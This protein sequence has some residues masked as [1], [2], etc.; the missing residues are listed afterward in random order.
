MSATKPVT[1]EE[2]DAFMRNYLTSPTDVTARLVFADW[3]EETCEPHNLA[4]AYYIRLRAEA[5]RHPLDSPERRELDRQADSYAPKV[6]ANL[7]I[8]ASLF[9]GYPKSLLQ[10][11]PA[12]N[13]TVRL[14][15]VEIP[16]AVLELVPESVARDN[17]VLSLDLQGSTLLV[18]AADPHNYDTAQKLQFIL[19]RDIVM[20]GAEE[21]DLGRAIDRLYE[22]TETETVECVFYEFPENYLTLPADNPVELTSDADAPVVRLANLIVQE[23]TSLRADRILITPEPDGVAVR[24]RSDD[25]WIDRDRLP[26]RLLG[27][28]S[29]RFAI[30]A[31]IPVEWTFRNPPSLTPWTAVFPLQVGGTLFHLRVTLQ[32]SPDGS[33]TQIDFIR[34]PQS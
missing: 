32:P 33:T 30:M 16:L 15:E 24:L 21:E 9:V 27:S 14:V 34:K 20:V 6:R 1:S 5:E 13:I 11:L 26:L 17:L 8:P 18:A 3:L 22:G 2:A 12:P 10:L 29:A 31:G 25:E 7:T 28:I 19:N 4:W 23:A